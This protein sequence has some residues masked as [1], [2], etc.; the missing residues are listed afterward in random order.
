MAQQVNVWT[1]CLLSQTTPGDYLENGQIL[2]AKMCKLWGLKLWGVKYIIEAGFE[3]I[4]VR[5]K[6]TTYCLSMY[7][8]NLLLTGQH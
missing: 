7:V 6:G 2:S 5:T 1:M 4:K 3:K 8:T